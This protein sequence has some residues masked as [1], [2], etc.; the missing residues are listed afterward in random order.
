M[1]IRSRCCKKRR[2]PKAGQILVEW[3]FCSTS[4]KALVVC[5]QRNAHELREGLY[6]IPDVAVFW[7]SRPD[8]VPD[9]PPLIDIEILSTDDR[10]T[11]V[12]EKLQEYRELGVGHVWLV[13]PHSQRLYTCDTGLT[14]VKSLVIPELGI[15]LTAGQIFE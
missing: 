15:E 3:F 8:A 13:D 5:L 11:A 12:R 7:P 6:R 9:S 2:K 10:L 4:K 1:W 14:E